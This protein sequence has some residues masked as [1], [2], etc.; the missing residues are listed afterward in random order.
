[1]KPKTVLMSCVHGHH[2]V[3]EKLLSLNSHQGLIQTDT[4]LLCLLYLGVHDLF[5]PSI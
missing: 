4:L 3:N 2:D 5:F 1:M